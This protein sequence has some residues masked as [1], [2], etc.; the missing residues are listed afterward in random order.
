M[1]QAQQRTLKITE[2]FDVKSCIKV[3]I[4][5]NGLQLGHFYDFILHTDTVA[6]HFKIVLKNNLHLIHQ[7]V[8]FVQLFIIFNFD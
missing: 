6:F 2:T 5:L 4:I 8:N 3:K 7:F 1:I